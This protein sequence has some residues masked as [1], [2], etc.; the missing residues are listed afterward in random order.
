MQC[1][2]F[3]AKMNAM[4]LMEES[5]CIRPYSFKQPEGVH[6]PG[7]RTVY[8]V[9]AEIGLNHKPKRKPNAI[10]KADREAS[11]SNDLIKRDFAAEKPLEKCMTD[12]TE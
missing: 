8:R 7:E 3:A 11:K 12:M 10:T 1:L 6:I 9:M 4:T 2:I 5:V